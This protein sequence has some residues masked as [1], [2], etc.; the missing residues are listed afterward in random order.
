MG[1][2]GAER[3]RTSVIRPLRDALARLTEQHQALGDT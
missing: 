1:L 3:A 2:G